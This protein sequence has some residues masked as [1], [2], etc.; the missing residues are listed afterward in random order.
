MSDILTHIRKILDEDLPDSDKEEVIKYLFYRKSTHDKSVGKNNKS[1]IKFTY[2][3]EFLKTANYFLT[4]RIETF[5]DEKGFG[6]LDIKT[7]EKQ[8]GFDT[9]DEA[10]IAGYRSAANNAKSYIDKA[11]KSFDKHIQTKQFKELLK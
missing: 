10:I 2:I 9:F 8:S 11:S 1:I 6:F 7:G 3:G 4:H 5:E